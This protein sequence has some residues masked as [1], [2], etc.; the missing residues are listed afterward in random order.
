MLILLDGYI[1]APTVVKMEAER[2]FKPSTCQILQGLTWRN[3]R[4]DGHHLRIPVNWKQPIYH[5][6]KTERKGVTTNKLP[7]RW[8]SCLPCPH[9][10]GL[11]SRIGHFLAQGLYIQQL[12]C[13]YGPK[14]DS[15]EWEWSPNGPCCSQGGKWNDQGKSEQNEFLP[16]SEIKIIIS[17]QLNL[18][19]FFLNKLP[20]KS[21]TI[22]C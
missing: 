7:E 4:F 11:F 21:I 14:K 5:S 8:W 9:S 3:W 13:P 20:L 16:K 19:G 22:M 15:K 12:Q 17:S 10:W 6:K 18:P 2:L 1:E